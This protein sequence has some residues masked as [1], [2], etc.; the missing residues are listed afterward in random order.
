[1]MESIINLSEFKSDASR[2]LREIQGGSEPLVLT[3]NGKARAVVEDYD[4]HR[5]RQ[6]ALLLLKLMVQGETDVQYGKLTAQDKVFSALRNRLA[7]N[8]VENG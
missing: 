3:Q 4:T 7:R 1:M 6:E 2:L 5:R 8:Q